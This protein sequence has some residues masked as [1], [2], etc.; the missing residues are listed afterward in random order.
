MLLIIGY[1]NTL[2]G[3]DS[4]GIDVVN[5][6]ESQRLEGV[7]TLSLFQLAPEVCLECL[8]VE[9]IIFVDAG[10]ST[11]SS[12]ALACNLEKSIDTLSHHISIKTIKQILASVYKHIPSIVIYSM[13]THSFEKIDD[14]ILYKHSISKTIE[15]IKEEYNLL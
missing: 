13:L 4:F 3:E 14:E 11:N 8:D 5:E 7:K 1:G 6:I 12:Y 15:H 2:R 10:Y 9:K